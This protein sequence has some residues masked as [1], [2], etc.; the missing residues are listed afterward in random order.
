MMYPYS[1]FHIHPVFNIG[2]NCSLIYNLTAATLY[3]VNKLVK[4]YTNYIVI[5]KCL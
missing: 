4:S 1:L 3:K 2:H 5:V